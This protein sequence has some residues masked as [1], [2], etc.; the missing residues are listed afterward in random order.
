MSLQISAISSGMSTGTPEYIAKEIMQLGGSPT[1]E[2]TADMRLLQRLRTQKAGQSEQTQ[3]AQKTQKSDKREK[4]QSAEK[5]TLPW[6][7]LLDK[8]G[9]SSQGSK[10]ADIAA[11]TSKISKL[12]ATAKTS[13]DKANVQSLKLELQT[14]TA[15]TANM[16]G[17]IAAQNEFQGAEQVS[18]M[19]KHFMNIQ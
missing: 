5:Q 7:S 12:E 19:N 11:I 6:Q 15:A 2:Y 4:T 14:A 16:G 10:E 13:A 8:L 3:G 9:I 1:G 17:A 18:K